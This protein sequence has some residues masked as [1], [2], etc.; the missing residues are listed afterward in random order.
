MRTV[1]R[2]ARLVNEPLHIADF[3]AREQVIQKDSDGSCPPVHVVRWDGSV[4]TLPVFTPDLFREA[5]SD[6]VRD[7]SLIRSC[8]FSW[9]LDSPTLTESSRSVVCVLNRLVF[10]IL[11][12]PS[13]LAACGHIQTR[14][15]KSDCVLLVD[16]SLTSPKS[17]FHSID[18]HIPMFE[19]DFFLS[20]IV[21]TSVWDLELVPY[22]D[23]AS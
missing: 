3:P 5:A 1:L 6:G 18:N 11:A 22:T 20:A 21:S 17:R 23:A 10:E 7:T 4:R 16:G 14:N 12:V 13:H 19:E 15:D 8:A 2:Q 9:G